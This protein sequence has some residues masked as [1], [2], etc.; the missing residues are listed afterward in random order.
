MLINAKMGFG[1]CLW[2]ACEINNHPHQQ[3]SPGAAGAFRSNQ[4]KRSMRIAYRLETLVGTE[5]EITLDLR[6]LIAVAAVNGVGIDALCKQIAD[7]SRFGLLWISSTNQLTEILNG[8]VLLQNGRV[9]RTA[10]HE[11][12]QLTKERTLPVNTIEIA[13][14]LLAQTGVFQCHYLEAGLNDLIQNFSCVAVCYC[15]RLNHCKSA[16][17]CHVFIKSPRIS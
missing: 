6:V 16:V 3:K 17:C 7:R 14:A 8:V 11:A 13:R 5:E 1:L 2:V 15:I 4:K 12:Y 9:N 10:G